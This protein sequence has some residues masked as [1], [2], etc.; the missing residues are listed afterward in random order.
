MF[1]ETFYNIL[2][3]NIWSPTTTFM[4]NE[5]SIY[6]GERDY[7]SF[8]FKPCNNELSELLK[9][10]QETNYSLIEDLILFNLILFNFSAIPKCPCICEEKKSK[11]IQ[12]SFCDKTT[13]YNKLF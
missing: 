12:S 11:K 7:K 3:W 13:E 4:I 1:A 5:K 9:C 10:E 8:N 2:S 6:S